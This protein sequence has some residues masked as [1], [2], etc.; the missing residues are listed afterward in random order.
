M[1]REVFKDNFK[2]K[3]LKEVYQKK[4][5]LGEIYPYREYDIKYFEERYKLIVDDK[6]AGNKGGSLKI[7]CIENNEKNER[8]KIIYLYTY[9]GKKK[10][11]VFFKFVDK[12]YYDIY[13]YL[14]EN[15]YIY[16]IQTE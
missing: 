1:K 14:V 10:P 6:I 13:D 9:D 3:L 5:L 16:E 4:N 15:N 12:Q 8:Q 7:K 2:I 11:P